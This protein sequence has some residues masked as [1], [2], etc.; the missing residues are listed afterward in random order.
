MAAGTTPGLRKARSGR[1]RRQG[2]E[3]R[4]RG[5]RE[6]RPAA[7]GAL[8]A[9]MPPRGRPER[10]Q[11]SVIPRRSFHDSFHGSRAAPG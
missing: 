8:P 2:L 11:C 5:L 3:P 10:T 1:V 6:D 4:T 9:Q 7:P